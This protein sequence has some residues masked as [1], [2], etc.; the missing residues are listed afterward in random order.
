ML[1][2]G[3][4]SYFTI[5]LAFIVLNLINLFPVYPLDG[6]QI[7]NRVFLDEESL[8][9]KIFVFLSIGVLIWFALFG[10]ARP[11]YPLLLFPLMMIT[12]MLG[13]SRLKNLEKRIS[14]SG[15]DMDKSY[16]D[17]SDQEYWKVR[18]IVIEEHPSFK[19]EKPGPPFEYSEKEDKIMAVIQSLLHRHLL[20]D[21]SVAGKLVIVATWV[22]AFIV[23][24]ALHIFQEI[25]RRF[26][27]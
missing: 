7:L 9:S 6:G 13:E 15:V 22:A 26:G 8:V 2:L 16:D 11:F 17:L 24:W 23:P 3:G 4:L 25:A 21:I 1:R 14:E 19:D 10:G 20:Q 27:Y 5:S 12:R 18:A